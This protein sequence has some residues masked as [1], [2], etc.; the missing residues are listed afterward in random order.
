[1]ANPQDAPYEPFKGILL[2]DTFQMYE[3]ERDMIAELLPDNSERRIRQKELD[4]RVIV[5]NPPYSAAASERGK[6]AAK[7]LALE[8][9]LPL[10][11]VSL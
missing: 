7:P 3:Q 10:A 11:S 8:V 1:L 2:T 6:R 9:E 4:I 5:G